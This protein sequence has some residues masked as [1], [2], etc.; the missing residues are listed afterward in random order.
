MMAD[1]LRRQW[2]CTLMD[3]LQFHFHRTVQWREKS[4]SEGIG[5][6][7]KCSSDGKLH[8]S[9]ISVWWWS[10]M[11]FLGAGFCLCPGWW[12]SHPGAQGLRYH[13]QCCSPPEAQRWGCWW[14]PVIRVGPT[15]SSWNNSFLHTLIM[16]IISYHLK[17]KF[18]NIS[19]PHH[20]YFL[21]HYFALSSI[22]IVTFSCCHVF[23]FSTTLCFTVNVY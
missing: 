5:I 19:V 7:G 15:F 9:F 20:V 8:H 21:S 1:E 18:S 13:L 16:R 23:N 11:C 17:L 10:F 22:S 6:Q 14:S 2:V 3:H 4:I 12:A